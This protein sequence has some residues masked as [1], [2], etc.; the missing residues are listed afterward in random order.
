MKNS[1]RKS[2]IVL[3]QRKLKH[4]FPKSLRHRK[5]VK[6]RKFL[7]ILYFTQKQK[8]KNSNNPIFHLR[9]QERTNKT[10]IQQKKKEIIKA[11]A[12]IN[13][14]KAKKQRKI[15]ETLY[16]KIVNDTD[17]TFQTHY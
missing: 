1:N 12:G 8:K 17:K 7:A 13:K 16:K 14:T 9:V 3:R 5:M 4:N 6:K 2:D 11:R 10:Q 15:N